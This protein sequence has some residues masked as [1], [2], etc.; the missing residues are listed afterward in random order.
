MNLYTTLKEL[1][2]AHSISGR[3]AQIREVIKSKIENLVDSTEVDALGNLI[4]LKKGRTGEKRIML[5]AHMDEI[6][7]LV[8]FI[9]DNG[10]IRVAP[11]GGINFVASSFSKMVSESGVVG[12][13]VP[14]S[15][16]KADE[17]APDKMFI[18]IGASSKAQAERKVRIGDAFMG[19]P[20]LYKLS[21]KRV[22]G[23]P[24]DD[25]VGCLVLL[26]I[27]ENLANAE[28]DADVYYVFSVQEEVGCRGS[29][30]AT[31]RIA[32]TES[33]CVDVTGTGDTPNSAPMACALGKGA[34]I[35]IKDRSVI[36]H[37]EVVKA[38]DSIARENKIPVQKEILLA[39]GT[40]TSSMQMI[41][42]G[43]MAGA[44]SIPT[45]YIHSNVESCDMGDVEATVSLIEKYIL[46]RG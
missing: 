38:L 43:S 29:M 40:D 31:Y 28:L 35:K 2:A 33:I 16:T 8:N 46:A 39:G 30:T 17:Y 22:A 37:E 45:R 41:G 32:P 9:E 18:D 13:L 20:E 34:A 44:V 27:A 7:F 14:N 3:E 6:G 24:I 36:C 25:R 26:A 15:R 42:N 12:V 11:I 4:A 21:G 19:A 1:C 23:R 10:L 5:C